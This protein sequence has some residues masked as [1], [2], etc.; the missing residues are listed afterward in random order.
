M[1][2]LLHIAMLAALAARGAA[3]QPPEPQAQ[4]VTAASRFAEGI[5]AQQKGDHAT[6]RGALEEA[7]TLSEAG[8]AES[9]IRYEVLKALASEQSSMG[10]FEQA[11]QSLERAMNWRERYERASQVDLAGDRLEMAAVLEWRKEYERAAATLASIYQQYLMESKNIVDPRLSDVL[12]RQAQVHSAMGDKAAAVQ[13]SERAVRVRSAQL[14]EW[15]PWL[16]TALEKLGFYSLQ[17]REYVKA[18]EAYR[19]AMLIRER[20]QG[21]D[22][23]DLVSAMDGL[24]Y[25][26][27][28]QKKHAE[29][30]QVYKRL[31]NAWV[32]TAGVEHPMVILTLDKLTSLYRDCG[33]EADAAEAESRAVALRALFHATGLFRQAGELVRQKRPGEARAIYRKALAL[34]D[35]SRSEHAE[36]RKKLTETIAGTPLRRPAG[37]TASTPSKARP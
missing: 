1:R 37:K 7:R 29:A 28:G 23:I 25:A 2:F 22:H 5:A 33:R 31:L 16:T 20:T 3:C 17:A 10:D 8:P 15:H 18:E 21:R 32:Q 11:E 9:R 27:Y 30:E 19:R 6:A 4:D 26:L 24:A 13:F 35:K 36:L 34:L 14:G 12:S